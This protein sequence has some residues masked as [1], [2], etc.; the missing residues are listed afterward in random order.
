[1]S[2]ENELIQ[3]VSKVT[4]KQF[5]QVQCHL[6]EANLEYVQASWQADTFSRSSMW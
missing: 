6:Y 3:G 5:A 2:Q 1:M 4:C